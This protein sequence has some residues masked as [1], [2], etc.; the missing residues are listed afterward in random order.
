[1]RYELRPKAGRGLHI[2]RSFFS[3]VKGYKGYKLHAIPAI[4]FCIL[5]TNKK[6][7]QKLKPDKYSV[8]GAA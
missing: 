3:F 7:W 5:T 6:R 2:V 1:M 8:A 4:K